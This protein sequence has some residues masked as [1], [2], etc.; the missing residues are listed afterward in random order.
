MNASSS[1]LSQLAVPASLRPIILGVVLFFTLNLIFSAF[2]TFSPLN[3]RFNFKYGNFLPA[4]LHMMEAHTPSR[5]DVLFLGTSQTNN[6]FIPSVFEQAAARAV[7]APRSINSFNLGLPNNRYDI[8]QAYLSYHV[9][10]YGRPR[11]V[12]VELSPTLQE[13]NSYFYYLPALYY[14]TLVEHSPEKLWDY[15]SHPYLAWN[16]KQEL[17]VSSLSTLHQ[18][19]YTFSPVN[20][21]GKVSNKVSAKV[22]ENLSRLE[23][24]AQ[25]STIPMRAATPIPGQAPGYLA[26]ITDSM[27]EKGWY[28][29][30]QSPHMLTPD[31]LKES[32]AEA[33][34]YYIE[35]QEAVRFE[36]LQV[37]LQYCK[38][39][40]LPVVLVAWPNHPVYW[41]VF[42]HSHLG[43]S[44]QHGLAALS[45]QY[46]TPVI[47]LAA[48]LPAGRDF[49][50]T[51]PL[52]ADPR[53]LTP[54]GALRYSRALGNTLMDVPVA[55]MAL[56]K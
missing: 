38:A 7:G 56:V 2:V 13:Q 40:H 15:L 11:L 45:Q 50:A 19:R 1:P 47:D 20:I 8:M 24:S 35:H 31:G 55:R 51:R 53:H 41:D 33:R 37:L 16:V 23:N 17:F 36:K 28:P 32:I 3:Q 49:S 4:K 27:M 6:G 30:E 18:Y 22:R 21:L 14:R 5:L 25:A 26:G 42:Q 34:S 54:Q 43:P 9:A 39:Q 48:T 10:H 44:Y 12:L 46:Q 52:F 29:K